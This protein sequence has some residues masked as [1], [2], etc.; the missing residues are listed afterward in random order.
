LNKVNKLL[1]YAIMLD[2]AHSSVN[3]IYD[4]ADRMKGSAKSGTR[5]F[6]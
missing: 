3:T 5:V 4:N 1:A 6:V 2:S